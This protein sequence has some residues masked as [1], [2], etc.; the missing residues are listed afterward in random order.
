V[1]GRTDRHDEANIFAF[2]NFANAPK[3]LENRIIASVIGHDSNPDYS[4]IAPSTEYEYEIG[5]SITEDIVNRL[6]F[7]QTKHIANCILVIKH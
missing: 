7:S 1:D 5:V 3:V 6:A 4:L 2:R